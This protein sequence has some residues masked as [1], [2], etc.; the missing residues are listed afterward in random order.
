[1]NEFKLTS[2]RL[3]CQSQ[4][5]QQNTIVCASQRAILKV[6]HRWHPIC[7]YNNTALTKAVQRTRTQIHPHLIA[8][9]QFSLLC[10][11]SVIVIVLKVQLAPFTH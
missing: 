4:Q 9:I 8:S 11:L 6:N 3:E 5:Q 7:E 10:V 1:M 2:I